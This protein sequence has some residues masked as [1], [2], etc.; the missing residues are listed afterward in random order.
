M[1]DEVMDASFMLSYLFIWLLFFWDFVVH[2]ES[3]SIN[4]NKRGCGRIVA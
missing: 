2:T 4:G 3:L 1:I